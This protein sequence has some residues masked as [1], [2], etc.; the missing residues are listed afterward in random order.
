MMLRY[1]FDL[2]NEGDLVEKAVENVLAAGYRTV[3]LLAGGKTDGIKKVGTRKWATPSSRNW[4]AWP[5]RSAPFV[6]R[7]ASIAPLTA[8]ANDFM[9]AGARSDTACI[10]K[11]A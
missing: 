2:G 11:S 5:D 6:Y 8:A 9:S 4:T 1:C 10:S 3:D 7:S